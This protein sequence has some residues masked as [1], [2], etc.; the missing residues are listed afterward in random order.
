MNRGSTPKVSGMPDLI[1]WRTTSSGTKEENDFSDVRSSESRRF[2]FRD[3]LD[4]RRW[5]G[6]RI[7]I[8]A[9]N[10]LQL[11]GHVFDR[12]RQ[13]ARGEKDEEQLDHGETND[14]GHH[15]SI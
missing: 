9:F 15:Q 12:T 10:R 2:Q 6:G 3:L 7:E 4:I 8:E 1:S 14:D 13:P 5:T 11:P